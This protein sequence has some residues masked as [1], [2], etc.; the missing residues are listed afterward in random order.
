MKSI[1]SK[2]KTVDEAIFAG[3]KEIGLGIDQVD[4]EIVQEGSKG[5]LGI[6]KSAIVRLIEKEVQ[7]SNVET[8]LSGLF[9]LMNVPA[10]CAVEETEENVTVQISGDT[11]G[12]L[13]GR[14]GETLDALQYI[15]GLVVNKNKDEY[16]RILLDSENYRKKREQTLIRLANKLAAKVSK[17]GK[18]VSLEPMN[19]YERRILHATLQKNPSVETYSEGEE[20]LRRVVIKKVR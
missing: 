3:L 5:F 11:S 16:R 19:P 2:G 20:P 1:E 4:I 13:I 7:T 14:R 15:T 9:K 12:V 10:K 18:R 8:F 17:T 6:G